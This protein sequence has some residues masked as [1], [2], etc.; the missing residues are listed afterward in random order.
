MA[1]RRRQGYGREAVRADR[2]RPE[3]ARR[4]ALGALLLSLALFGVTGPA[5]ADRPAITLPG[6]TLAPLAFSDL[7]GWGQD[8]HAA[9]LAAFRR[10]CGPALERGRLR[11]GPAREAL[12]AALLDICRALRDEIPDARTFFETHF[13]PHRVIPHEVVADGAGRTDRAGFV[14]AYFEPAMVGSRVRTE[15]FSAPL[16]RRPSDLVRLGETGTGA[17]AGFEWARRTPDGLRPYPNRGEIAGGAIDA[18]IEAEDLVIAWL[19]PVD[20]FYVHI[21]GS[22][23]IALEG[24]ATDIRVTFAAKSGHP[25]T[26][27]GRVLVRSGALTLEEADM[28][29]IRAW[30]AAHPD[31]VADIL[32]QNASYI[33][34]A[35]SEGLEPDLGPIGA[36]GV[37]L[38]PGRSLAVDRFVHAFGL[39]IWVAAGLDEGAWARLMVAQDTGSAIVGPARGDLFLGTGDEAGRRAGPVAAPADFVLLLPRGPSRP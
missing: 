10:S 14:T 22:A 17:L 1:E 31:R 20:A 6:A 9:A 27:I 21:Q 25:Y 36:E 35:V 3:V 16:L 19:D 8:D 5:R 37:P 39:P 15:R 26:A 12:E 18:R 30:L 32:H 38:T 13:V 29:G 28:A 23:R 7:E 24:E 34:F 33:F 2:V 4:L 11:G